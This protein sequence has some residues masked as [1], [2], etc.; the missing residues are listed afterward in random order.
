MNDE[1]T[2]TKE[3]T[4]LLIEACKFVKKDANEKGIAVTRL[5]N[6]VAECKAR[7]LP[8]INEYRQQ[9]VEEPSE[10]VQPVVHP[11]DP[12]CENLEPDVPHQDVETAQVSI[13]ETPKETETE[14]TGH[15]EPTKDK[16]DPKG[17]ATIKNVKYIDRTPYFFEGLDNTKLDPNNPSAHGVMELC[18]E[19]YG[20]SN[21]SKHL[22][23]NF[24]LAAAFLVR[25]IIEQSII[26]YS[27]NN[28]IQGQNKLVYDCI[29][30]NNGYPDKFSKIIKT[31]VKNIDNFVEDTTIRQYFKHLFEDYDKTAN[32]FN[33]VIHRPSEFIMSPGQL[34]ELPKGGLLTVINYFLS[35]SNKEN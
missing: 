4:Q 25:S 8:W 22:I 29:S 28:Y 21:K 6:T 33:W 23:R 17:Y 27:K 1:S 31:Y 26:Y 15:K 14:P 16:A 5:Y 32:P 30:D 9:H 7:I 34:E 10:D 2:F 20:F 35:H 12:I 3:R 13:P 24:P 18:S 19:L 11:D